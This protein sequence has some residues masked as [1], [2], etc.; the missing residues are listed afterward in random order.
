MDM[1][2]HKDL[3]DAI[4]ENASDYRQSIKLVQ[5][6]SSLDKMSFKTLP[7]DLAQEPGL[8]K[9]TIEYCKLAT[10]PKLSSADA[11]RMA[12]IYKLAEYDEQLDYW[13]ARIDENIEPMLVALLQQEK[14]SLSLEEFIYEIRNASSQE[15]SLEEFKKLA[16][17]VYLSDSL[18]NKYISFQNYSYC[19]QSICQTSFGDIFVISWKP[20]QSSSI[21]L[22]ENEFSV[23]RVYKGTLTHELYEKEEEVVFHQGLTG[24]RDKHILKEEEPVRE[25]EWVCVNR[26]QIHRLINKSTKTLVTLHFRLFGQPIESEDD[27]PPSDSSNSLGDQAK[28]GSCGESKTFVRR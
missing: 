4:R 8:L 27:R 25:N 22:H 9:L 20:G 3:P 26:K 16:Q 2:V 17:N 14:E 15:M 11:E 5:D 12:E 21:H 18:V 7:P 23:I 19:R 28:L 24:W 10:K 1:T 13:I 6:E